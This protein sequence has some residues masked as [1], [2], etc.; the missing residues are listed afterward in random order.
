MSSFHLTRAFAALSGLPLMQF[1]RRRRLSE[2]AKCL[3]AGAEDI[4]SVALDHGYHSHEAFSRAFKDC[5]QLTPEQVRQRGSLADLQ[6]TEAFFMNDTDTPVALKPPRIEFRPEMLLAG[7]VS[8]YPCAAPLG[9]PD[10]W[11]RF[12]PWLE[13]LEGVQDPTA[14]GVCYNFDADDHFDYLTAT[15]APAGGS[16]PFGLV[17][18]RLPAQTYA[19]FEHAGPVSEIRAVIASIWRTGLSEAGLTAVEGPHAGGLP[20]GL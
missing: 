5:F 10:Q 16:L 19:M 8:R 15:E 18:L 20:P 12:R 17:A 7:L 3:A 9:I 14:Y 1:V 6:L 13:G 2:A 4:L 11:Q